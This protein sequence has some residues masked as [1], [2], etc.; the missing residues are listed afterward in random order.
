MKASGCW[1]CQVCGIPTEKNYSHRVEVVQ[2]KSVHDMVI[3]VGRKR[4]VKSFET[5]M[6]LK[7][8]LGIS[9]LQVFMFSLMG[10][11][12]AFVWSFFAM[13]PFLLLE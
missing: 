4:L 7:Q 8:V 2:E 5:K 9:H 11:N 12:L 6:M 3:R 10:F 1:R 13:T